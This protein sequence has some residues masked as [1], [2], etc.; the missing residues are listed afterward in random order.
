M[1]VL[2]TV[3]PSMSCKTKSHCSRITLIFLIL[4]LKTCADLK[5]PLPFLENNSPDPGVNRGPSISRSSSSTSS[6]FFFFFLGS[7]GFRSSDNSSGWRISGRR[8]SEEF[9]VIS[10]KPAKPQLKKNICQKNKLQIKQY[11][12]IKPADTADRSGKCN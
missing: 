1:A 9:H 2:T 4:G 8:E 7:R 10:C 5:L 6:N 3:P 12:V 11:P